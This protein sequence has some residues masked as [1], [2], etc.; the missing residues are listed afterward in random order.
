MLKVFQRDLHCKCNGC[1]TYDC[2][3]CT[4]CDCCMAHT[5]CS[6]PDDEER[7]EYLKNANNNK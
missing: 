1:T 7:E 3:D 5:G 6:F 4:D 2:A